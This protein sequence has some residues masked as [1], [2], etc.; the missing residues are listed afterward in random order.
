MQATSKS[1]DLDLEIRKSQRLL[2]WL[3]SG[4]GKHGIPLDLW[5]SPSLTVEW[6]IKNYTV[7][8]D[9]FTRP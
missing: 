1:F 2:H 9:Y 4:F 3:I 8:M 5:R 7:E 6:V